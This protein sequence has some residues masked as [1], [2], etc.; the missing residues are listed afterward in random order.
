MNNKT[1]QK[2]K[3]LILATQEAE[4]ALVE[5]VNGILASGVPCYFLELIIDKIHNQLKD[6]AKRELSIARENFI[7]QTKANATEK[8]DGEGERM[9][10]N[11]S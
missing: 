6:G 1:T 8:S 9:V 2:N 11:G 10:Q 5:T 3:P 7:N 4:Q